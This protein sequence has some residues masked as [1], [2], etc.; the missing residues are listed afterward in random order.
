M[1]DWLKRTKNK[2]FGAFK[3]SYPQAAPFSRIRDLDAKIV[4]S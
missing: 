3:D 4:G 1:E 2:H